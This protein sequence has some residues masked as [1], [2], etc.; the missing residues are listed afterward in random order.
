ML[1]SRGGYQ[2][3]TL[4]DALLAILN[5]VPRVA[6]FFFSFVK[7]IPSMECQ[8]YWLGVHQPQLIWQG[9]IRNNRTVEYLSTMS[10]RMVSTSKYW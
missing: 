5:L 8:K 4:H 10:A 1:I 6:I 7:D 9:A 2:L 3:G